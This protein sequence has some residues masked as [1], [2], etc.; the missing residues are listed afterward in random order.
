VFAKI[1]DDKNLSAFIVEKD[2]GGIT[3][4]AEEHKLG[5]KGSST[6][7]VFF[8]DTKVPAENLLSARG[9][10]FKIALNILNSGRIKLAAGATGGSKF[11]IS[12]AVQY[13]I[14]RKQFEQ[15]IAEFGAMKHK[16]AEM[17]VRTFASDTAV[18]RT[19]SNIDLK[20]EEFT[21]SGEDAGEAKLKA[22]REYAVECALLKVKGSE[23]LDYV[24]DESLQI[25]GGMGYAVETGIEMG[26]R[27][28]RITRIYEGT[29][30]INRL[31][32]VAELGKRTV[33]TKEVNLK[34]AGKAIPMQ[35]LGKMLPFSTDNETDIVENIKS[36][37]LLLLNSTGQKYREKI[38]FEQ[39]IV[40]NLADIL[41]EA[42]LAESILLRTQKLKADNNSDKAQVAIME[43]MV[44]VYLY[45]A[46]E[47]TRNA[48]KE[49]IDAYAEGMERPK[50]RYLTGL[51]TKPYN[52]NA[53][54]LRREIADY[55]IAKKEYCF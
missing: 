46:L 44:Q 45:N 9:K 21:K 36:I 14:D 33:K 11:A 50:M 49:I 38:E 41:A 5:I 17:T 1:E 40:M 47:I 12:K 48:A 51:L 23:T 19:G 31:L 4:G 30:E 53:K 29:N 54:N 35:L 2:F 27:D 3:I 43:K 24:I 37:F 16:I 39:E 15:S 55:V 18:Y 42:Y 6:V 20:T 34:A 52:I 22:L 7:Q 13:A 26:Y 28:A 32:S 10:G 8:N 25:H